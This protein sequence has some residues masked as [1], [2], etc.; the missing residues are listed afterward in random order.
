MISTMSCV[1]GGRDAVREALQ[2]HN[3]QWGGMQHSL[4][5]PSGRQYGWPVRRDGGLEH[6]CH[7][8]DSGSATM[9]LGDWK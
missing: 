7:G 8:G 2:C 9:R 4:R 1:H 3:F 5:D 6:G